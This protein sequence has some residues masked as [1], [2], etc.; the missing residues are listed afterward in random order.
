MRPS[1]NPKAPGFRPKKDPLLDDSVLD[2]ATRRALLDNLGRNRPAPAPARDMA[3]GSDGSVDTPPPPA[4]ASS[5]GA[6]TDGLSVVVLSRLQALEKQCAMQQKE[7]K[8][9]SLKIISLEDHLR[10]SRSR[11]NE[12]EDAKVVLAERLADMNRFLA[13]YGL[14]FIGHATDPDEDDPAATKPAEKKPFDL[15][16]GEFNPKATTEPSKQ[17]AAPAAAPP[18]L[19]EKEAHKKLPF[20]LVLAT[21]QADRLSC[22]IANV[23]VRTEGKTGIIKERD[24]VHVCVYADGICINSG[25]FRPYG[26]PLCDAFLTDLL[27][28][29]FP[30][31]FRDRYPDGFPIEIHDKSTEACPRAVPPQRSA[32][33]QVGDHGYKPLDRD[34]LLA[35]VP[36]QYVT[37]TGK[38]VDVR[39]GVSDFIGD[40][41][42]AVD[43]DGKPMPVGSA[44]PHRVTAVTEAEAAVQGA[45]GTSPSKQR[46][47]T[48]IRVK[49]AQGHDVT[50]RMFHDDTVDRLRADL[51][52]AAAAF[53]QP[54]AGGFEL[55]SVYPRKTFADHAETLA[56]AGLVPSAALQIKVNPLP[57]TSTS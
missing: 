13:D 2:A 47:T 35:R 8:E 9:K 37:S 40:A 48:I 38:L 22:S 57:A 50:L 30:Y 29:Y 20:D 28:G 43:K 27:E 3:I 53:F 56:A 32:V 12:A 25:L 18:A 33:H 23:T 41:A 51:L 42:R 31:E 44:E 17:A 49:F 11:A 54:P 55:H 7:L 46:P 1:G 34:A 24:T 14:T 6:G 36:Q 15:Y 10:E 52:T 19:T 16:A 26:W 4:G 39:S 21:Q 5:S 45:E